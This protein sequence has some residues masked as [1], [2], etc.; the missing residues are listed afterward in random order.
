MNTNTTMLIW[1]LSNLVILL[2]NMCDC[3]MVDCV[4]INV[5]VKLIRV[6]NRVVK[7]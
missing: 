7:L 6:V 2:E 4:K 3:S 1:Y 5:H